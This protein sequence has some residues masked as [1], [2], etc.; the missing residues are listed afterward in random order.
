MFITSLA[1]VAGFLA[2][3]QATLQNLANFGTLTAA[4]IVLA[5]LADFTFVPA[6]LSAS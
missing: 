3:A 6:L 5:L 2:Y 4:V 1:L